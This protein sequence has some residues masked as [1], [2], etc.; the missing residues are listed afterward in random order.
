MYVKGGAVIAEGQARVVCS[1]GSQPTVVPLIGCP[2]QSESKT[3]AGWTAGLGYEFG[4]TPHMSAKSEIMYF[5]VGSEGH[6]LA[7]VPT[8]LQKSGF[9]STVGLRYRFGN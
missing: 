4:L 1:T 2:T 3:T 8:N 9:M 7:G 6:D 5:D